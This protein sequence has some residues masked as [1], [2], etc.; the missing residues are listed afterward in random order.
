MSLAMNQWHSKFEVSSTENS[1]PVP[2]EVLAKPRC[3]VISSGVY[4]ALTAPL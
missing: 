1:L 4:V 3:S 2:F